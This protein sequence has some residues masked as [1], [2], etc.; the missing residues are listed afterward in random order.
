MIGLTFLA[1][2]LLW[3]AL[4]VF[5]AVKLPKW[6]GATKLVWRGLL[7]GVTFVILMVGP[8]VDH[9][10]G[11]RQFERLCD[12]QTGLQIYPGAANAKRA[13]HVMGRGTVLQG[14]FVKITK[15]EITYVNSDDSKAIAAY[16]Y[17]STPGGIVGG[18]LTKFGGTHGCS[19]EDPDSR[20]FQKLTEFKKT[21]EAI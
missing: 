10:V 18:P 5:L 9:I 2:G 13:K 19:A 4:S 6:F 1:I 7:G 14:Y 16:N 3:L 11:M 12:E 8:F 15:Y 21:L 17:F 20:D